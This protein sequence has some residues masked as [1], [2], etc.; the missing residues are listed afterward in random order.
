MFLSSCSTTSF[1]FVFPREF[2]YP[3]LSVCHDFV[4]TKNF[5]LI[6]LPT[7]KFDLLPV[8]FGQKVRIPLSRATRRI[9]SNDL[10]FSHQQNVLH[11]SHKSRQSFI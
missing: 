10:L 1:V 9:T 3:G 5:I 7:V 11:F 8:L 2:E 4:I 6:A